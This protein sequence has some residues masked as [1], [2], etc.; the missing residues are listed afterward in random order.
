MTESQIVLVK[1]SWKIV[2]AI[3]PL[4][5]G[6]IFYTKL[7]LDTPELRPLFKGSLEEQSRKLLSMLHVVITGLDRLE[8]FKKAIQALAMRHKGYGVVD[9][10]YGKVGAALLYTLEQG[11]GDVFDT[12]TKEAWV[13][14]YT[15][16]SGVMMSATK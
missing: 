5:V 1:N 3:D 6:N 10:H 13:R 11:L 15:I 12:P 4:V 9:E 14:C 8:E 2:A 7:F 16:L